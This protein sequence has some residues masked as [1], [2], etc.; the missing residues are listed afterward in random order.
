[1]AATGEET[2][3]LLK[4]QVKAGLH[5][6]REDVPAIPP[7]LRHSRTR[8]A[9]PTATCAALLLKHINNSEAQVVLSEMREPPLASVA[10][11]GIAVSPNGECKAEISKDGKV[12]NFD[13][14]NGKLIF[15]ID[16]H[17]GAARSVAFSADSKSVASGGADG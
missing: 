7:K 13:V 6:D 15:Q 3:A 14:K 4:K 11:A 5:D 16:P 17:R 12:R 9:V 2:V 1:L 8:L 10:T